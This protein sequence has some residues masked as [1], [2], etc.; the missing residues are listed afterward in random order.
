MNAYLF[1]MQ[2]SNSMAELKDLRDELSKLEL[3]IG[4]GGIN[5]DGMPKGS[6]ISKPTER[7]AVDLASKRK[8][9][10][11]K[12]KEAEQIK[13]DIERFISRVR[14]NK[15][16]K[17]QGKTML[18]PRSVTLAIV[19][20]KRYLNCNIYGKQMEW[21]TIGEEMGYS[22]AHAKFLHQCALRLAEELLNPEKKDNTK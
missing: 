17:Y 1:L 9:I 13:K 10:S 15:S 3:S 4:G 11:D 2:Y 7:D 22:E 6:N 14:R 5:Y 21:K 20:S 12:E 8:K 19:L 16:T 18:D